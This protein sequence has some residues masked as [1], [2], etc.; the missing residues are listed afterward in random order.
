MRIR[1]VA[2]SGANWVWLAFLLLFQSL[3]V[4]GEIAGKFNVEAELK[5]AVADHRL[6]FPF[7]T[8]RIYRKHQY[9]SLWFNSDALR[10]YLW[11]ATDLITNSAHYGL[12]MEDYHCDKVTAGNIN[13]LL[14]NEETL[15]NKPR[16]DILL[17]DAMITF[18]CDLHFGKVNP[19]FPRSV[20][21]REGFN[22]LKADSVLQA[23][24]SSGDFREVILNVQPTFKGYQD[25][26][27]YNRLLVGQ[28]SGD[29]Y[30]I[31]ADTII[32]IAL[33]LERWRWLN[34]VPGNFIFINL[35]AFTLNFTRTDSVIQLKIIAGKPST[36]TPG[37]QTRM[38]FFTTMPEWKVPRRIIKKRV[39][40]AALKDSS[41]FE[42][43]DL[44]I[45]TKSGKV[46][47]PTQQN[48][49]KISS[50]LSRYDISQYSGCDHHLGRIMFNLDRSP[51]IYL[52]EATDKRLFRLNSR[53]LSQGCIQLE[54][55]EELANLLIPG[56]ILLNQS[57]IH[58]AI[59]ARK[60]R[61]F[62]LDNPVPV[63]ISYFTCDVS[64][65]NFKTFP[66]IYN[67]DKALA[68]SLNPRHH[69]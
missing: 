46:V 68:T 1:N 25:L 21:D 22:G 23:A 61:K 3:A 55:P 48:L 60:H 6:Q 29:C 9:L 58:Q 16:L 8:Q 45:Y 19:D 36:P 4:S 50:R 26:Q 17:T 44:K 64:K 39:I 18:I 31:P 14:N 54:H 42:N 10:Q 56:N 41:Y 67:R 35:A 32:L 49:R 12:N 47:E 63:I 7:M 2:D 69:N 53:A 62:I 20:L 11:S 52:H 57:D 66:D 65:G 51:G 15:I 5:K 43:N 37:I 34:S 28:L 30:E 13:S 59:I 24:L 38:R 40:P 27:E 33:N